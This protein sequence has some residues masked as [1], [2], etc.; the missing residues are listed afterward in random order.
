MQ[1]LSQAKLKA[2][3]APVNLPAP[4]RAPIPPRPLAYGV[5][6]KQILDV[7]ETI[8]SVATVGNKG[9]RPFPH[10]FP[11]R[12]PVEVARAIVRGMSAKDDV[13]CDPMLGSGTTAAAALG[14]GRR[15]IGFDT[16]PL[17]VLLAIAR[18]RPASP[19]N[20]ATAVARVQENA[21][22]RVHTS[23]LDTLRARLSGPDERDFL[24]RW[25]PQAAQLQ[26]FA[27]IDAILTEPNTE[28]RTSLIALF[29]SMIITKQ[30]GVTV[31]LDV[32]RSRA[33]YCAEKSPADPLCEWRRR[34]P[35]FIRHAESSSSTS[36]L[37]GTIA[38][39]D[40]R[41]LPMA[42]ATADLI[43]TSPPYLDA[44][45]YMRASRFS[46]VWLSYR[47][48]HLRT[49]RGSTI[50]SERGLE[51]G[52]LPQDVEQLLID[53]PMPTRRI[54]VLRRYLLDI[55]SSL[56]E[57]RRCTKPGGVAVYV[58]GPSLLTRGRYD[59]AD[60]IS[61]LAQSVGWSVVGHSRRG[62]ASDR[63]SLPPPKYPLRRR[64]INKR[65][66][67]EFYVALRNPNQAH[68]KPSS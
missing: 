15:S 37:M 38:V 9:P 53:S 45:D 47:L 31:G 39:G 51:A 61:E 46:L 65:M 27:L 32:S 10:P 4:V 43:L 17:A 44:I 20:L 30:G 14:L 3:T 19:T 64:A 25:F 28:T 35:A 21:T 63:R 34:A 62:I 5:S 48:A 40:A 57:S 41:N 33:H 26:L 22:A 52:T 2:N 60:V 58:V 8:C 16:D 67:C 68:G 12:M 56:R 54:P 59:G 23:C 18:C 1:T 13:V 50:G 36:A 29:S 49:I 11:A 42:N 6:D 7:L 24:D 55:L 66:S